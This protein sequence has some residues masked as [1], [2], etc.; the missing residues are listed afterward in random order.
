MILRTHVFKLDGANH[1]IVTTATKVKRDGK[2]HALCAKVIG[3]DAIRLAAHHE[4]GRSAPITCDRCLR[5]HTGMFE[6]LE[7]DFGFPPPT[8]Y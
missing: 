1:A 6:A 5:S 7:T 4:P 8:R 3:P 2:S